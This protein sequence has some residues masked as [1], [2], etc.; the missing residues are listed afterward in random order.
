[1]PSWELFEAQSPEYQRLVLG[2]GVRVAVEAA[3]S[4]GWHRWV[5]ES[6]AVLALDRFGGSGP[7]QRLMEEF[8]F[9]PEAVAA[10][11]EGLLGG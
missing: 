8:G 9:T 11:A 3:A 10:L 6:G 5:G 7:G 1:M 2:Q 4:L